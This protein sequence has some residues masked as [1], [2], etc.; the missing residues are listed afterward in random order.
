LDNIIGQIEQGVSTKCKLNYFCENIAFVSQIE[1][2]SI[3]IALSVEK[4]IDAMNDE[5]NQFFENN[6]W[7][8]VPRSPNMYLIGTTW[9]F[10]NKLDEQGIIVKNKAR[11][12]AKG[13][14]Q[15]KGIDFG[16]TYAPVA[17]LEAVRLL[18]AYACL[19]G[20]KLF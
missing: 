2:T 8:L 5:L 17:R 6:V 11:L 9:V 14:N 19:C 12:V 15:E 16:E 1:P 13:Y 10:R 3:N 20:F 4:W 7:V 18:L